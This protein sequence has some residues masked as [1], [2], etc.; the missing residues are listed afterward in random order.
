MLVKLEPE[1]LDLSLQEYIL[2]N[3]LYFFNLLI[4]IVLRIS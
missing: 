3:V 2:T 1:G 4:P